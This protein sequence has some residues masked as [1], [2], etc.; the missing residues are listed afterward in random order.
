MTINYIYFSII[1][2]IL[3]YFWELLTFVIC[4]LVTSIHYHLPLP[5]SCSPHTIS[6]PL[7]VFLLLFFFFKNK[8]LLC[9]SV[10]TYILCIPAW[11]WTHRTYIC[12]L[13][14]RI[15]NVSWLKSSFCRLLIALSPITV[16]HLYV[17]VTIYYYWD[18]GSLS[19]ALFSK[20]VNLPLVGISF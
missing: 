4:I 18:M 5:C 3:T 19:A 6:S 11:P 1:N 9:T 8:V 12:M 10:W 15:H 7:H 20:T 16:A 13:D 17:N 2:T 14:T